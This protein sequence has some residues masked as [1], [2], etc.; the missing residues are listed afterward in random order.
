[1]M[2]NLY[3]ALGKIR[4]LRW[5]YFQLRVWQQHNQ[6]QLSGTNNQLTFQLHHGLPQLKSIQIKI[7]GDHNVVEIADRV[8]LRHTQILITGSHN[9]IKIGADCHITGGAIW[10]NSNHCQLDIQP[11]T[12]IVEAQIGIAENHGRIAIGEDCMLSHGID[13]RCGDSHAIIDLTTGQRINQA[14]Y[15]QIEPHVWIGMHSRILKDVTIAA[16]SVIAAGSI[17][18]KSIPC[19]SIAAGV[20]ATVKRNNISWSREANV[21]DDATTTN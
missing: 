3:T 21:I 18:T 13:I 12:T 4:W 20:P 16:N 7:E 6:T 5:M 19:N 8:H 14:S 15:I 17:V 10:I 2:H 9:H 11:K 1:P